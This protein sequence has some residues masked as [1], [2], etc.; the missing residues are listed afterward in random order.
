VEIMDAGTASLDVLLTQTGDYRLVVVDAMR[1]PGRAGTIYKASFIN[2]QRQ[3]IENVFGGDRQ[4]SLHQVGLIDAL[5]AAKRI[6]RGPN[7]LIIIGVEPAQIDW[8]L[9][10]TEELKEKVPQ[11][12]NTILEEI[13]NAVYEE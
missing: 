7:G 13:E 10:L 8:G 9:E 3:R 5:A 6:G 4:I 11:I 2:A 1:G 12:V